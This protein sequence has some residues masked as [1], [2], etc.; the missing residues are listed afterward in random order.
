[1]GN[2]HSTRIGSLG[3]KHRD[4]MLR[5]A[6]VE[7]SRSEDAHPLCP[8]CKQNFWDKKVLQKHILER[9]QDD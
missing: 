9:H 8:K 7:H 5:D 1:M 4:N 6:D 2:E 3:S